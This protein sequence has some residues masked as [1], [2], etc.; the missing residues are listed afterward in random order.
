MAQQQQHLAHVP[1]SVSVL[2][3][4]LNTAFT[5]AHSFAE[6]LALIHMQ[7]NG[8]PRLYELLVLGQPGVSVKVMVDAGPTLEIAM[9]FI[10]NHQLEQ[11]H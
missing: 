7:T 3:V 2:P 5:A 6:T 10:Q 4:Q 9:L 8:R 1:L 11:R